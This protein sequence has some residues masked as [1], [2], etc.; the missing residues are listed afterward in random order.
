MG[1]VVLVTG[2]SRDVGRRFARAAASHPSIDRVIGVD[3]VPP[4]GDI[5]DVSFVRADIRSPVIAKVLAKEDV[6]TVVHMSVIATPG[7]AG[8]RNTMKEL[9]VMGTMQLLAACQKSPIVKHLVVKSTTT[10]YGASSRDPAMF[11]EEMGPKRLPS[12]GYAKDVYEVEGYVRGFARRRPDVT[13]TTIRAANVIGPDV[14]SP[15]TSYFR[16]PVLP[17]VIGFDPRLQFLH[18]DDLLDVLKHA[19]V[20]GVPGTFNVAG[21][22]ILMLSQAI[23][24]LGK[25]SV[26]MPAFAV[27]RLGSVLRQARVA[28]F[29]PEQ[30]GFLTFG[31]GVDTTRMREVLG[32]EPRFTTASAFAD[33]GVSLGVP[34]RGAV[35][36]PAEGGVAHV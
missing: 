25:P 31:R 28:D 19:V 29:S 8:G 18:E 33:F 36:G 16:L 12:S 26:S 22:G 10:M 23:R 35:L 27:G 17:R 7:S 13:V 14:V 24:R 11:T 20:S 5:G 34:V 4:R 15:L 2:I 6:D 1:R 30:I 3:V 21:D 9:N 32:F